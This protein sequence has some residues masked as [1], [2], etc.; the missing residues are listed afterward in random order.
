MNKVGGGQSIE[1]EEKVL[2]LAR[3]ATEKGGLGYSSKTFEMI[4]QFACL[5]I[6][7][8]VNSYRDR[9]SKERPECGVGRRKKSAPWRNGSG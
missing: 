6:E 4:E 1:R 9:S 3:Q 8:K 5:T 7:D 2:R